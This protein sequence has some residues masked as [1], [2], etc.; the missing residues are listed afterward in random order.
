MKIGAAASD[1]LLYTKRPTSK[2]TALWTLANI[3]G[4][5]SFVPVWVP[6]TRVPGTRV[7]GHPGDP[8]SERFVRRAR[9]SSRAL[10]FE[11]PVALFPTP[12]QSASE[13]ENGRRICTEWS[14]CG[15]SLS[16]LKCATW[17]A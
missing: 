14:E 7:P 5:L 6:A 1:E 2:V 11:C 16:N 4:Y 8:S 17:V 12:L 15:G 3:P 10:R 13:A 9:A